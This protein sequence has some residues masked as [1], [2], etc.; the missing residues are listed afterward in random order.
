MVCIYINASSAHIHI[1]ELSCVYMYVYIY[2][3]IGNLY[4]YILCRFNSF[5]HSP[6]HHHTYTQMCI[7][8]KVMMNR[9]INLL[10]SQKW[11]KYKESEFNNLYKCVLV[12][13]KW[14]IDEEQYLYYFHKN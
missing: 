5:Q 9:W 10:I 3:E 2:S 14:W 12:E 13:K 8:K 6:H 11:A 7:S 4:L 1:H